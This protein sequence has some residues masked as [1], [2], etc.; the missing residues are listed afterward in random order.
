M[1]LIEF[2]AVTCRST[3]EEDVVLV[4][5]DRDVGS[6]EVKTFSGNLSFGI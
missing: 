3:Q 4:L 2:L 6:K 1:L 5:Y